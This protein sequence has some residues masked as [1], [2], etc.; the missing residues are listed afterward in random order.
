MTDADL[1]DLAAALA[2][3]AAAAIEAV[4]RAG[5]AVERKTDES[6]VTEADRVAEALIVEALR[7][8]TPDWPVVA[9]EEVAAGIVTAAARR[10]WLVD[11]LDGTRDFAK[12]S[13]EYATCIGLIEEGRP[14]LGAIA[15]P[16]S[17]ELFAGRRGAG[18]WKEDAGGR[19]PIAV[20]RVPPEGLTV[21]ASRAYAE[22]P[23]MRPFLAGRPIATRQAVSSALK[24]CRV[25]EGAADLYPRF[26]GTM[27][28]DTAAGQAIVEAAGGSV[29]L[30]DGGP[31]RYGKPGWRNP[32]FVCH[33]GAGA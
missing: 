25:A 21:L 27:E 1:L 3:R 12:G 10:T 20:R 23:R 5:F 9:E 8:A 16:A 15:L 11:P 18:A 7:E 13:R 2:R 17:G 22:D 4:K 33:G 29:T 32:D 6:P 31:L 28:W 26:G 30:V 24:F 14:L 19:R